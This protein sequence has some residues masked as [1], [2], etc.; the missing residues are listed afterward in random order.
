MVEQRLFS[1]SAIVL[2]CDI[3]SGTNDTIEV[4]VVSK[5]DLSSLCAII[6][7]LVM[8]H[9]FARQKGKELGIN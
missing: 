5:A 1:H 9:S 3:K 7:A 2:I 8:S 4:T 6:L